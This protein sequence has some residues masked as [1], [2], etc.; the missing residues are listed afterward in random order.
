MDSVETVDAQISA[1]ALQIPSRIISGTR[2]ALYP[3]SS[4]AFGSDGINLASLENN[5][6]EAELANHE[7]SRKSEPFG[8]SPP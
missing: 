1:Q 7:E 3:G 6:A 5:L 4:L 2:V 8:R